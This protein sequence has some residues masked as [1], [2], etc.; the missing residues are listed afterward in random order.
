MKKAKMEKDKKKDGQREERRPGEEC[1]HRWMKRII[2]IKSKLGKKRGEIVLLVYTKKERR[3]KKISLYIKHF[4]IIVLL[5]GL[6]RNR[7]QIQIQSSGHCCTYK[8]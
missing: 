1:S 6:R 3:K 4:M 7:N 5:V 2:K 8:K